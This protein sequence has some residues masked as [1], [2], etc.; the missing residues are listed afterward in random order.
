MHVLQHKTTPVNTAKQTIDNEQVGQWVAS[1]P[2]LHTPPSSLPQTT[3]THTHT[4]EPHLLN[5]SA[6]RWPE[7]SNNSDN[8][9]NR[10][11][12]TQEWQRAQTWQQRANHNTS[13]RSEAWRR[14]SKLRHICVAVYD[15]NRLH[16]VKKINAYKNRIGEAGITT[17]F[18]SAG[19]TE[20]WQT[21]NRRESAERRAHDGD[22][23][24][25]RP[26]DRQVHGEDEL[27]TR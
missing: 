25:G 14:C 9:S 13:T 27:A 7:T 4:T 3:F 10:T 15:M 11:T 20:Y 18:T 16:T 12:N 1:A 19:N 6:N 8:H 17:L 24:S 5:S 2:K 22:T 23:A 21:T 26:R